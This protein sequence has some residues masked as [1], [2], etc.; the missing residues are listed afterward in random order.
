MTYP[1]DPY[2]PASGLQPDAPALPPGSSAGE[3]PGAEYPPNA[4]QPGYGAQPGYDPRAGYGPQPGY[5]PGYAPPPG[6]GPYP[7]YGPPAPGKSK[8]AA[9]V[10]AL[11]IG[12]L[13]IH[14]FYLGY[15]GKGLIQLLGSL[16]SCGILA[17][18]IWIWAF[19]EGILILTARPGE[20]PWGV[21]ANGLPLSS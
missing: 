19:V 2:D 4:G 11:L 9:G 12:T 6:Y 1:T 18:P 16:L 3:H 14:N 7:G 13:G 20:P 10:L 15:T 5:G 21:D 17:L 8:V